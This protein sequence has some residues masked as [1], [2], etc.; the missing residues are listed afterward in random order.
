MLIVGKNDFKLAPVVQNDPNGGGLYFLNI[1]KRTYAIKD[2]IGS[3]EAIPEEEQPDIVGANSYKDDYG[4]SQKYPGDSGAC[5]QL[6][7]VIINGCA[8]APEGE[9]VEELDVTINIAGKHKTLRVFGNRHWE[10]N[11]AGG[12]DISAT[13]PFT[14]M[15]IRWEKAFG[16]LSNRWNPLGMGSEKD[17]ETDPE[18]PLFSLPNVE[19]PEDLLT[20]FGQKVRPVG[21]S[22]IPEAWEPRRSFF[23][24]R[25][26]YWSSFRAPLPP[27]DQDLRYLNAAPED[28]QFGDLIGNEIIILTNMHERFSEMA[29]KLPDSKPRLFYVPRKRPVDLQDTELDLQD[30]ELDLQDTELIETYLKLDT[31]VIDLNEKF[32]TLV[33]K[34]K[35]E[36]QINVLDTFLYMYGV[37]D[38]CEPSKSIGEIQRKFEEEIVALEWAREMIDEN[39]EKKINKVVSDV[40]DQIVK[41]LKELKA[42]PA[43]ISLLA[44]TATL[45]EKEKMLRAEFDNL[46]ESLEKDLMKQKEKI[47]SWGNAPSTNFEETN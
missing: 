41:T 7:D 30:T 37:E 39:P 23:G 13:Q 4:R 46:K 21:F 9:A 16:S 43:L 27:K 47:R 45:D 35:L 17:H 1:V 8:F 29:I 28:Q 38:S 44:S 34:G 33:W 5:K 19:N 42:E 15:P 22:A 32:L 40:T 25:S 2:D 6:V 10:R 11:E 18:D 12:V 26:A 14:T 31:V 24:T 20:Q 3:L 36:S